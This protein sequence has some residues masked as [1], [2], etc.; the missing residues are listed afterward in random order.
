MGKNKQVRKEVGES[1]DSESEEYIPIED[2]NP[3][4]KKDM[5]AL[6]TQLKNTI[7][8]KEKTKY[9][10]S[11]KPNPLKVY[12]NK[13]A[14]VL[15]RTLPEEHE[16]YFMAVYKKYRIPILSNKDDWLRDEENHVQI[17]YGRSKIRIMLSAIYKMACQLSDD[18]E[19]KLEGFPDD[20]YEEC[21][22][23]IRKDI[24]LLHLYRIFREFAP[25]V[26]KK[27]LSKIVQK[28]EEVL[29]LEAQGNV[30]EGSSSAP[31][32]PLADL[33]KLASSIVSGLNN[34]AAEN[35]IS[36]E[37]MPDIGK[38]LGSVFENDALQGIMKNLV[39]AVAP[40]GPEGE[41]PSFENAFGQVIKSLSSPEF[42]EAIIQTAAESSA[43]AT[44]STTMEVSG[45]KG[46]DTDTSS[47]TS[48][49]GP[50]DLKEVEV[51]ESA[52]GKESVD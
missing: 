20:A 33:G 41:K 3:Q 14:Q 18:A 7:E 5:N 51:G 28:L 36:P 2:S 1:E 34:T 16:D 19:K 49:N 35:N 27:R 11:K 47:H 39:N 9:I 46:K 40:G 37:E 42:K 21:T 30:E 50:A 8:A 13:Y 52:K 4:L 44:G 6:I 25:D 12:L 32:N 22:D 24:I 17:S 45:I 31:V 29:G 10:K 23:L 43:A 48:P 38:V 26:D 15:E